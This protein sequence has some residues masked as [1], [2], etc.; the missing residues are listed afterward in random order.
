LCVL[1]TVLEMVAWELANEGAGAGKNP[2]DTCARLPQAFASGLKRVLAALRKPTFRESLAA[3]V[4]LEENVYRAGRRNN[5]YAAALSLEVLTDTTERSPTYCTPPF[6]KF[7]DRTASDSWSFLFTPEPET[8]PAWERLL[9]RTPQCVAW[10]EAE[11]R[12][13]VSPEKLSA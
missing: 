1:L 6:R 11:L 10:S 5:Y 8:R 2:N 9:R 7:D 12:V 4:A 13:L 3:L